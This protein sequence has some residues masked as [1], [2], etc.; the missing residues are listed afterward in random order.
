LIDNN[1]GTVISGTATITGTPLR[2][3]AG[4][5]NAATGDYHLT[6][7]SSA[8]DKG[9]GLA[10]LIDLDGATRPK[11]VTTDIGAYE[12]APTSLNNQTITFNPLPDKLVSDPPFAIS[13]TASSGL[14]VSFASLTATICTVSGNSVTLITTGTCTIQAGQAGNGNFNPAPPVAQS[15][16]VKSSQKSD[17]TITFGKPAD[18]ALG[19]LPFALS[20]TASSGVCTVNGN[21]VTLL[22]VGVCSITA[23]QEGNALINP[24]TP[25]TQSFAVTAQSGGQRLYLPLVTRQ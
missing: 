17:Q 14:P 22:A 16:A 7:A 4:F 23:T 13:A 24:A 3:V 11:G 12:F 6:A 18:R 1:V 8:V 9:N 25:V 21:S 5:V 2:G 15:F 10:P 19:D 20:A